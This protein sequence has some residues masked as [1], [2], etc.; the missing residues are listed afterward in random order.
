M[1]ARWLK[2]HTK[3]LVHDL[4]E[5]LNKLPTSPVVGVNKLSSLLQGYRL[6]VACIAIILS[7]STLDTY[8]V[9]LFKHVIVEFEQ[10]PIC[11]ALIGRDPQDLSWFIGGKLLGNLGV[12]TVLVLLFRF[13]YRNSNL[14]AVGV[15][16]FQVILTL[17]L[18]F[19][20]PQTGILNFDGLFSDSP[21][22]FKRSLTSLLLHVAT[23]SGIAGAISMI[24]RFRKS[25][26]ELE[27]CSTSQS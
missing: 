24:Y 22:L 18:C 11:L 21:L 27:A 10:N 15:A 7:V 25:R 26:F 5:M 16:A 8:F 3:F 20:D 14:V 4:D 23:L 9:Y 1:G 13:G 2:S 12:V 17:Y 19:A 6:P